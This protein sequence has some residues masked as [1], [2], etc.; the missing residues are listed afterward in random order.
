MIKFFRS[1][2]KEYTSVLIAD[3]AFLSVV[4]WYFLDFNVS[5]AMTYALYGLLY[6]SGF[7]FWM[8]KY[9]KNEHNLLDF[10]SHFL[11]I[12]IITLLILLAAKSLFSTGFMN[13]SASYLLIGAIFALYYVYRFKKQNKEILNV[14]KIPSSFKFLTALSV[15]FLCLDFL[16]AA[17]G[18][19]NLLWTI[20]LPLLFIFI[21]II[22]MLYSK[23]ISLKS[24][25]SFI[26][27][28]NVVFFSFF[29]LVLNYA[30]ENYFTLMLLLHFVIFSCVVFFLKLNNIFLPSESIY[31]KSEFMAL[32]F[33]NAAVIFI[34]LNNI[35]LFELP[36]AISAY[37]FIF[38]LS[39]IVYILYYIY[40]I[41]KETGTIKPL[42]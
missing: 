21:C 5:S 33:F 7:Y 8:Q 41:K 12:N 25:A 11:I 24:P 40:Q 4:Y 35:L 28:A 37:I 34:L 42:L 2:Q 27:A 39:F 15:I 13:I 38:T 32:M 3:A 20:Y 16:S 23:E 19:I 10:G 36:P 29:M 30:G 1:K 26:L 17:A 6:I 18:K 14:I 22:K 9:K 31:S